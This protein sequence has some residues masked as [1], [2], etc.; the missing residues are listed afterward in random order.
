[1]REHAYNKNGFF[2]GYY[3]DNKKW[4]LSDCDPD[5]EERLYLVSNAWA[6]ISGAADEKMTESVIENIERQSYSPNGYYTNSKG[7]A[8]RV[9]KAGRKGKGNQPNPATYNHAQ[10]FFVRASCL[11]KRPDLAYKA[12]RHI[13]PIEEDFSPVEKTFAPPYAIVN[14]YNNS[15]RA[16]FQFLSGTVSYVLRSVYNFFFGVSYGYEGL[17]LNP[18]IPVEFG[19]CSISLTYLGKKFTVDCKQGKDKSITVNGK[20][21]DGLKA[22]IPDADMLE[23]NVVKVIY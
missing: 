19:D 10:S 14:M 13:L 9:D 18:S 3:N 7:F 21:Y 6:I 20:K 12:T 4:L 23:D 22:F 8:V 11:A 16:S 5:G 17:S 2:N 1:M 15:H